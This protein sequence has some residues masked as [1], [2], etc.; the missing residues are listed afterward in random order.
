MQNLTQSLVQRITDFE[1]RVR[2]LEACISSYDEQLLSE[3]S[4]SKDAFPHN[5]I[6]PKCPSPHL[7]FAVPASNHYDSISTLNDMMGSLIP[8]VITMRGDT[9][10][11]P[12]DDF[13]VHRPKRMSIELMKRKAFGKH[14]LHEKTAASVL[15]KLFVSG[16]EL[17]N[18][19]DA[20]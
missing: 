12:D 8:V 16:N 15:L 1:D 13:V 11:L 20:L 9:E 4:V 3:Q 10:R 19:T 5:Q 2:L 7:V 18:T 17:C 14:S 6:P